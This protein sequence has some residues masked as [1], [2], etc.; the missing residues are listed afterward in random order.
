MGGAAA[1][2]AAPPIRLTAAA[3]ATSAGAEPL[4]PPPR[5]RPPPLPPPRTPPPPPP[6]I[7]AIVTSRRV[8]LLART[9]LV[10]ALA[11]AIGGRSPPP[12]SLPP[13]PLRTPVTVGIPRAPPAAAALITA[14]NTVGEEV[15]GGSRFRCRRSGLGGQRQPSRGAIAI[16][17]ARHL[18]TRGC[19]RR[20][21]AGRGNAGRVG[22]DGIAVGAT[23]K[24][25]VARAPGRLLRRP[26]GRGGGAVRRIAVR[27]GGCRRVGHVAIRPRGCGRGR[28][29]RA[30]H[31]DGMKRKGRIEERPREVGWRDNEVERGAVG[32][33][34]G[35]G[36]GWEAEVGG[37]SRA[38]PRKSQ[39]RAARPTSETASTR[40]APER[41]SGWR[42]PRRLGYGRQRC[43]TNRKIQI[44]S[45]REARWRAARHLT[46]PRPALWLPRIQ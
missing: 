2:L 15:G 28:E 6:S 39:K 12:P 32:C 21:R 40:R 17:A 11:A 20:R 3:V 29:V 45:D 1:P 27:G 19:R 7:V 43:P 14:R 13:P 42:G 4:E 22:P 41:D 36:G 30:G 10:A 37:D 25:T 16:Q 31:P 5:A 24:G 18:R 34:E 35:G 9:R 38:L 8:R 46:H 44:G 33:G 26:G 23:A